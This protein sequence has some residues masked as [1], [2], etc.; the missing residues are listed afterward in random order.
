MIAGTGRAL[1]APAANPGLRFDRRKIR[2][3][4]RGGF[5]ANADA[6]REIQQ[7]QDPDTGVRG[8][9]R[10]HGRPIRPV[11]GPAISHNERGERIGDPKSARHA[12]ESEVRVPD[13]TP[14]LPKTD[15]DVLPG[16]GIGKA[17]GR[18]LGA[19]YRIRWLGS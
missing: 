16:S 15:F 18:A 11:H 4:A 17:A 13:G 12:V 10:T 3:R 7:A 6:L 9:R 8:Y 1:T 5:K 14:I 19:R 2:I